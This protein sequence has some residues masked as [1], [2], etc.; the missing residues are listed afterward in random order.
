MTHHD[1]NTNNVEAQDAAVQQVHRAEELGV[2]N[3][4]AEVITV[5]GPDYQTFDAYNNPLTPV[6]PNWPDNNNQPV[7][8]DN[9]RFEGVVQAPVSPV[10]V[11]DGDTAPAPAPAP[12]TDTTTRDVTVR[13]DS[14]S[15][16]VSSFAEAVNGTL[17]NSGNQFAAVN[18]ELKKINAR[19]DQLAARK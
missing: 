5:P 1:D 19:L 15:A 11:D 3:A 17:S 9:T 13:L 12:A 16:Q 2:S 14:L 4:D 10:P 18:D 6:Q 8:T 7:N